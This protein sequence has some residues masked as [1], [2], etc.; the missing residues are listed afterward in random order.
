MAGTVNHAASAEF[1]SEVNRQAPVVGKSEIEI[2]ASPEAVWSV[3]TAFERWPSWT[4][5]QVDD[6]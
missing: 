2:A 4:G 5:G 3:L 6:R 1:P